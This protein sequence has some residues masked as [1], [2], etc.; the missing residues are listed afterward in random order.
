VKSFSAV[1]NQLT[2]TLK[3]GTVEKY[4]LNDP[5]EKAA[6]EK[7]FGPLPEPPEPPQ[8]MVATEVT[9]PVPAIPPAVPVMPAHVSSIDR[10]NN[11]VTIK[12][13]DGK[14]ER[15]DLNKPEE[16]RVLR[17]SMGM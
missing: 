3:D 11:K 17:K 9:P 12:Q 13:K 1:N 14:V 4:N 2:V 10:D 16:K 6:F 7:K 15:Y 8:P 5:E